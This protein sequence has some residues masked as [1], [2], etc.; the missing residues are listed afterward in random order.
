M[1]R[2]SD[3]GES[4]S[5]A[6]RWMRLTLDT[7]G[8]TDW[9]RDGRGQAMYPEGFEALA[10]KLE[11]PLHP[12]GMDVRCIVSVGMLTEGWDCNTVTH[13]IGLRPFMSQLL[14]EQVVGRGLRRASYA[15]GDD[16]RLGEEVAK[17]LGVPFEIVPLKA[18]SPG[19]P[20]PEPTTWRIH[21]LPERAELEIRFPRVEGYTQTIRHRVRVD[22]PS[23]AAL[24]LDPA[25]I[26]PEV[27]MKAGLPTNQGRPSLVGPGQIERVDLSPFRQGQRLQQLIFECARDLT[28]H[29]V[30]QPGC[31]APTH[32]LFAQMARIVATYLDEKVLAVDPARDVDVFLSPWYGWMVERLLAAI[33]PDDQAGEATELPRIESARGPGSTEDVDYATRREPYPVV[34]SHINAVV[35]DTAK[36]EQTAA[37]RLDSHELVH[38]FVKNAG[39]GF[40]IP[41][42]HNGEQHEYLPDFIVRLTGEQERF[43]ILETKGYDTLLEVKSQAAQRWVRA[44][45]ATSRFGV[46]EYAVVSDM[47]NVGNAVTR[48]A[49]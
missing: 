44:V 12:P 21:A 41:Y 20:K 24:P 17:I 42:L 2:E 1:V 13:I 43:L 25:D 31:D 5:D 8:K 10:R 27:E 28:R 23:I 49:N 32:A 35:P 29:F 34:K 9:P 6:D 37:Y 48:A 33:Q 26:P 39:L 11:K 7:V 15:L 38:S 22:W 45:N 4:K 16:G 47:G 46:W 14:C 19:D 40:A 3:S 36:W 30:E 18:N